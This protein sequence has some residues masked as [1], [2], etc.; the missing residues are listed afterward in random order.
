MSILSYQSA[1]I[2]SNFLSPISWTS[3]CHVILIL[4][5]A[6]QENKACPPMDTYSVRECRFLD[7][8]CLW[9]FFYYFW[10]S[11]FSSSNA[12]THS[13]LGS[14]PYECQPD[15]LQTAPVRR[16]YIVA[17]QPDFLFSIRIFIFFRTAMPLS[18]LKA[19]VHKIYRQMMEQGHP[20]ET[21]LLSRFSPLL[22]PTQAIY[23]T[24]ILFQ[25]LNA[26]PLCSLRHWIQ[27]PT[28]NQCYP[29]NIST[30]IHSILNHAGHSVFSLF[31]YFTPLEIRNF[32]NLFHTKAF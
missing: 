19:I 16:S 10:Y 30:R 11:V 3:G 13:A 20:T 6:K 15:K 28:Q 7:I 29:D 5:P 21:G 2:F 18:I 24:F 12:Y 27:K 32:S 14:N 9:H 23:G 17:C 22:N 1:A 25:S 31:S 4:F 26:Y 8:T